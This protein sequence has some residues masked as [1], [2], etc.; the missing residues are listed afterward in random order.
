MTRA[1][2]TACHATEHVTRPHLQAAMKAEKTVP[3]STLKRTGGVAA[4]KWSYHSATNRYMS[5]VLQF[6]SRR[7]A[8]QI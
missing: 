3:A 2:A 7:R 5:A 8:G 6:C 1:A 4:A